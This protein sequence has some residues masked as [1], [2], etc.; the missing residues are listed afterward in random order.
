MV[1]YINHTIT[2]RT[3]NRKHKRNSEKIKSLDSFSITNKTFLKVKLKHTDKKYSVKKTL[4]YYPIEKVFFSW[5]WHER[6]GWAMFEI[7]WCQNWMEEVSFLKENN[8][9]QKIYW[10]SMSL[11]KVKT[12]EKCIIGYETEK[13]QHDLSSFHKWQDFSRNLDEGNTCPF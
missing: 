8:Q 10:Y 11:L 1:S 4:I 5:S 13:L 3:F 6:D 12:K 9:Y 7:R 2:K